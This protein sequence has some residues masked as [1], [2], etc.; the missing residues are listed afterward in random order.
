ML[1]G[2]KGSKGQEMI[3]KCLS[4]ASCGVFFVQE[5]CFGTL[6]PYF[7]SLNCKYTFWTQFLTHF[8]VSK[9]SLGGPWGGLGRPMVPI[10]GSKRARLK[11]IFYENG[12]HEQTLVYTVFAPHYGPKVRPF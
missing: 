1:D 11:P 2:Q 7:G 9:W 12:E 8:W 5:V 6:G 4:R 10:W 3:A